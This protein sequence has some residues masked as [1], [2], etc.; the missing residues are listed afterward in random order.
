MLE[1]PPGR[2]GSTCDR[3]DPSTCAPRLPLAVAG[4]RHMAIGL[5]IEVSGG[6]QAQYDQ[7]RNEVSPN[8][9]PPEGML[10]HAGGASDS[11]LTVIEVWESQE[12]ATRFF[13]EK[14]GKAV[15]KA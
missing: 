3:S 2:E 12:A 14:L 4:S 5:I 1:R 7:V 15:E 13:Q 10:Y 6:T 8:N 9:R 11:G